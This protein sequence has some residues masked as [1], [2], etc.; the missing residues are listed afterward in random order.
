[1]GPRVYIEEEFF[2][3][4]NNFESEQIMGNV[5]SSAENKNQLLNILNNSEINSEIP[6]KYF[7]NLHKKLSQ[8]YRPDNIKDLIFYRA[9]RNQNLKI[10]ELN[11]DSPNSV[12]LLDK[13]LNETKYICETNNV[14]GVSKD[15][16]FKLPI[17]PK[18]FA[19]KEVDRN[20]NGIDCIRHRCR[21]V[22]IVEP[23][24]FQDQHNFEPK[25]PN[26]IKLL[27]EL[28]LDND[29]TNC[30]LSIITNMQNND[31]KFKS[32][33]KQII[34]GVGNANLE[35]SVYAHN[36]GLFKNNRHFI[37][38]YCIID[39]QHLFDRDEASISANYLYDGDIS[40]NFLRVQKLRGKIIKCFNE[41]PEKMGVFT[42]K[43]GNI[44]NNP[45]FK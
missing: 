2:S 28:Y 3:A 39:V 24:L 21:N 37:T 41:D 8:N 29:E 36:E 34:D 33:I 11:L 32:K 42:K 5:D 15:Y 22:I 45:L 18:T 12:F 16:N 13:C 31:G 7:I 17:I 27:K 43:F 25:T 40:S 26:L 4:F 1:M 23:Y 10:K 20:M 14:I 35:V 19:S 9:F 44:L 38:D 30:Y 6:K